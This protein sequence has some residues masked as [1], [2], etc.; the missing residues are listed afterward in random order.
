MS[1]VQ[2]FHDERT[3]LSF[4]FIL[5]ILY[6]PTGSMISMGLVYFTYTWLIYVTCLNGWSLVQM[7]P[8]VSKYTSPMDLVGKVRTIS[9]EPRNTNEDRNQMKSWWMIDDFSSAS[10]QNLEISKA[11]RPFDSNNKGKFLHG[12]H[13]SFATHIRK[14][15][16]EFSE[17]PLRIAML[18]QDM[19]I[20]SY[21]VNIYCAFSHLGPSNDLVVF[22][23]FVNTLEIPNPSFGS[24]TIYF[25]NR[26]RV[27]AIACLA[28]IK[29]LEHRHMDQHVVFSPIGMTKC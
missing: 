29:G 28:G 17:R 20:S 3:H 24:C 21:T 1:L 10:Y 8:N 25:H 2:Q 6:Y 15:L 16:Q 5:G 11:S 27:E 26:V 23:S 19:V 12:F 22:S 7:Y 4:W 14:W 18:S 9:F 13:V